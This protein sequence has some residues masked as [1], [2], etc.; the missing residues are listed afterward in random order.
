MD[1]QKHDA[2]YADPPENIEDFIKVLQEHMTKCEVEGQYVEAEMAKNRIS[3]LKIKDYENKKAEL[4]F[5]QTQ[6]RVECEEA[7]KK[8]YAEFNA[9]WDQDLLQTQQEDAQALGELEDKHTRELQQLKNDL[10]NKLPLT[11]K[12]S[13]QLLNLQRVQASHAKQKK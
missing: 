2:L 9:Q 3:E 11:F 4:E 1:D 5:N 13:P 7:H 10:E 12:F 6:Q 8:Q